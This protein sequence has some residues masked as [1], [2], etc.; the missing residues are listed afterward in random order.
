M[1]QFIYLFFFCVVLVSCGKKTTT[2]NHSNALIHS[3]SPYL[4]EHAHNP[5]NWQPWGTEALSKAQK[6]DKLLVISIGYAACHWCHVMERQSFS[7]TTVA[8]FMNRNFV[9]IKVDREERPDVDDI[10][11]T[12]CLLSGNGHCGWPLNVFA[13]P[14]GRP[15]WAGTYFPKKQWLEVLDYFQKLYLNEPEKLLE[16]AERLQEGIAA[17]E[18]IPQFNEEGD[19][20]FNTIEDLVDGFLLNADLF[21]GGTREGAP[22]FPLPSLWQSLQV[23][24]FFKKDEQVTKALHLT[25]EKMAKGGIYDQ[26]GGGF[27]RY[28]TDEFWLVP[29][30]EK[31]LYDN[32]Q[33]ISLYANAYRQYKD[34]FYKKVVEE[35]IAYLKKEML[36]EEGAF[37]ASLNADSEGVEGKFYVWKY[38]EVQSLISDTLE[39]NILQY[40]LGLL[41]RGNWELGKN[42][43]TIQKSPGEIAAKFLMDEEK[44]KEIIAK[45]KARLLKNRNQRVRP[46][47]DY[48]ILTAWNAMTVSALCDAYKALDNQAYLEQA[49]ATMD[50]LMDNNR[51]KE[52]NLYRNWT[53]GRADQH[54]FLDDYATMIKALCDLYECTFKEKYLKEAISLTDNAISRFEHPEKALFYY[55]DGKDSS[56]IKRQLNYTDNVVPSSNA[57]FAEALFTLGKLSGEQAYLTQGEKAIVSAYQIAVKDDQFYDYFY[58]LKLAVLLNQSTLEIVATGPDF[59]PALKEMEKGYQPDLFFAGAQEKSSLPLLSGKYVPNQTTIYVCRNRVCRLPVTD[60][61]TAVKMIEE[62]RLN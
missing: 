61:K 26:L 35:S 30:F 57:L 34:P 29:H 23:Y 44:V 38:K 11:M 45:G 10:Y 32:A 50:F 15:V 5:V 27:S 41:P 17:S 28:S 1:R 16:Y 31:M 39:F 51:D 6:E 37:Y 24:N 12:A 60:V 25:L 3:T 21:H 59:R 19:I 40:H 53:K 55:H 62:E 43:L 46:D 52:E 2:S 8:N 49:K 36:S 47:V 48:K 54:G 42:V 14:D 20:Q 33:L 18:D 22:K 9:S 7:D 56:L 4:L 13:L 58:W